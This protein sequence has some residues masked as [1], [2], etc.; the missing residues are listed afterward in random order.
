M[1]L[2]DDKDKLFVVAYVC[3]KDLTHT[4]AIALME[5]IKKHFLEKLDDS[6]KFFVYPVLV[7]EMQKVEILN[8]KFVNNEMIQKV[9]DTYESFQK[10]IEDNQ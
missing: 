1:T 5:N 8:P 7:P 4:R 10:I 2:L 3:V 9:M 6:V